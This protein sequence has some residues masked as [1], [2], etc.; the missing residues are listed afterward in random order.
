MREHAAYTPG[1]RLTDLRLEAGGATDQIRYEYDSAARVRRVRDGA[2]PTIYFAATTIAPDGDYQEVTYG[3]G[4]SEQFVREPDGRRQLVEWSAASADGFRQF[5]NTHDVAGR[6]RHERQWL[7]SAG[8][9]DIDY[10]YDALGQLTQTLQMGGANDGMEWFGHDGL[11]NLTMRVATTSAGTYEYTPDPVDADRLCLA[12]TRR[13]YGS[14]LKRCMCDNWVW[15]R[16]S[17]SWSN[18]LS[19]P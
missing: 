4:V 18:L 15:R 16:C 10:Q 6:L 7:S 2:G 1:G 8:G 9:V 14:P 12:V 3:N 11:G 19:D 17:Q 5:I 13:A